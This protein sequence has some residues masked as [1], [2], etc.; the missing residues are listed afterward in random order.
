MHAQGHYS[1]F[2][3]QNTSCQCLL[4]S[5]SCLLMSSVQECTRSWAIHSKTCLQALCHTK[6]SI[7]YR[8]SFSVTNACSRPL[9][10]ILLAK[11]FMPVS[12]TIY[13]L[14]VDVFCARM[15]EVLSN[16]QQNLV[17]GV[18]QWITFSFS[19]TGSDPECIAQTPTN[20]NTYLL[21]KVGR[22]HML[23]K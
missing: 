15:H 3:L 1:S 10:L 4:Q 7:F 8:Y 16:S 18:G 17:Q 5:T 22:V 23:S 9:Q 6:S 21:I 2:F 14:C 11:Y 20:H 13:K 12:S 19:D